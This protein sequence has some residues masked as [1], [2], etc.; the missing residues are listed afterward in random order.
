MTRSSGSI[1]STIRLSAA[2]KP[3][4]TCR[5]RRFGATGKRSGLFATRVI[6][7][8]VRSAARNKMSLI[9]AGQAS[10]ST[11]ICIS[12]LSGGLRGLTRVRNLQLATHNTH[13]FQAAEN[14]FRHALGEIDEAMILA[15]VDVPDVPPL[16]AGLIRNRAHNIPG[17]HAVG[18]PD[19][20][21]ISLE[22]DAG[23]RAFWLP[24]G[25]SLALT[26][27]IRRAVRASVPAIRMARALRMASNMV[28]LAWNPV[29]MICNEA[30][31]GCSWVAG[32]GASGTVAGSAVAT[33]RTGGRMDCAPI[34]TVATTLG[35]RARVTRSTIRA[36]CAAIPTIRTSVFSRVGLKSVTPRFPLRMSARITARVSTCVAAPVTPRATVSAVTTFESLRPLRPLGQQQRRTTL[37]QARQRCGDVD[38]RDVLLALKLLNEVPE[39]RTF[40]SRHR[41]GDAL[42]ESCHPLLIHIGDRRQTHLLDLLTRGALNDAQHVALARSD[43][44]DRLA[45]AARTTRT[46]DT[47]NI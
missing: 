3:C 5:K 8:P 37:Q 10:A 9:T 36:P 14:L 34:A 28:C 2:S 43:K 46:S 39:H 35:T 11:Q 20:D 15:N 42:L 32:T 21:A 1:N 22:F 26:S 30:R 17:L 29:A 18:M 6:R 12:L 23:R 24:R 13:F 27:S 19:F 16:Q 45:L 44:Q 25:S 38:H 7:T 41:F 31:V 40:A 47:V 33:V 4:G